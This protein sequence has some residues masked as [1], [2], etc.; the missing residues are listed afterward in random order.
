M[1]DEDY[2]QLYTLSRRQFSQ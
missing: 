1:N 2:L